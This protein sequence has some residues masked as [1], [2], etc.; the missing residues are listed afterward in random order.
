MT[1]I[2]PTDANQ[3]IES[4]HDRW[5]A[6]FSGANYYYGD[7]PGLVARRAVRYHRA[8]MPQGATALDAGCGEGQ[9][10]AFLA[11]QNYDSY[12]LDFTSE[13]VAKTHRLLKS[14][15][16][17]AQVE[18]VDLTQWRATRQFDL[19][20]CVNAL[21]FLG[22]AAPRA[23]EEVMRSVA[24]GG[25]IGLSLFAREKE[26]APVS[27]TIYKWTLDELLETFREWQPLESAHLQQWNTH[28]Q[29][30]AFATLIARNT[31]STT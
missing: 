20:L 24:R 22:E 15:S 23:L 5:S 29:A 18:Q 31:F 12:G 21:Q 1:D 7:E 4:E 17:N 13:G 10:L 28:G 27:G 14:R 25:V 8:L 6:L 26:E 11:E 19:V 30:Q 9:D 3:K 16:L 2:F